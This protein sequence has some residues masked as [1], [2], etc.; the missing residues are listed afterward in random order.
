MNIK[1]KYPT[2]IKSILKLVISIT[3]LSLI[4][5]SATVSAYP[6]FETEGKYIIHGASIKGS[7]QVK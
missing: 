1:V 4:C 5:S 6:A 2:E 7:L 3:L